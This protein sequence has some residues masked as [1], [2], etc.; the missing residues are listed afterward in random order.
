MTSLPLPSNVRT[1][2]NLLGAGAVLVAL[3]GLA[4]VVAVV[5][6][7]AAD[8]TLGGGALISG[9][10]FA[11]PVAVVWLVGVALHA[12]VA[13]LLHNGSPWGRWLCLVLGV[14][15]LASPL[16][17]VGIALIVCAIG[18]EAARRWW[19]AR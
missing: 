4:A 8:P 11:L 5:A 18:D 16:F 14:L 6:A 3:A 13:V 2:R 19:S 9:V 15:W 1:A 17:I 12:T 10:V 7:V